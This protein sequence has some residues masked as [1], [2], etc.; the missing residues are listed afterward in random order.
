VSKNDWLTEFPQLSAY[1]QNKLYKIAGPAVV[2]MEV[3]KISEMD[4]YRP[5]FVAYPLSKPD[6]KSCM[7]EPLIL[8]QYI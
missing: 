6:E 4:E 5:H 2:G 7:E 1:A 8:Q 3:L